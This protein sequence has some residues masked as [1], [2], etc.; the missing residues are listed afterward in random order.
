MS[1]LEQGDVNK[2]MTSQLSFSSEP[3]QKIARF[4]QA[5]FAVSQPADS[6]TEKDGI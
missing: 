6:R 4:D 5:I 1:D 2:P 3:I